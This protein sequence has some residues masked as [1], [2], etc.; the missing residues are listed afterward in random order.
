MTLLIAVLVLGVLA[1]LSPSTIVV[2]IL[3]L[4]TTRG[5]PRQLIPCSP[6]AASV[7]SR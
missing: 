6:R 4:G 1:S 5:P 3:L 7:E 2:F